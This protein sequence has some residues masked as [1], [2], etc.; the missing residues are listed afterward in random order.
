MT[1]SNTLTIFP[2]VQTNPTI[3]PKWLLRLPTCKEIIFDQDRKYF[4]IPIELTA[5][6][7]QE[8][9][10]IVTNPQIM[11]HGVGDTCEQSIDD[12]KEMLFDYFKELVG[13]KEVLAP[14]LKNQLNYL[15][16]ILIE[17]NI[18]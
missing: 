9:Y 1:L 4:K 3:D 11:T 2:S 12:F 17:E 16:S 5:E 14:N 7:T 18:V 6:Q 10:W 13:T 15:R 8:G